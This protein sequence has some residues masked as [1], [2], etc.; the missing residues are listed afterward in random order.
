M[1]TSIVGKERYSSFELLRLLC[2]F[3]IQSMHAYAVFMKDAEGFNFVYGI[4]I[5]SVFNIGVSVFILISGYFG[6]KLSLKKLITLELLVIFY[7]LCSELLIGFVGGEWNPKNLIKAFFPIFTRKYWYMTS[8]MLLLLFSEYINKIPEKLGKKQFEKLLLMLLFVF[9][10]IPTIIQTDIMGDGGKGFANMFLMYLMG[11]YIALYGIACSRKRS[12]I[13]SLVTLLTGFFLN[14]AASCIKGDGVYTPFARDCSLI[15]VIAAVAI[16]LVFQN[17]HFHSRFINRVAGHVVA[18]YLLDI[19]MRTCFYAAV[20]IEAFGN[21]WYLCFILTGYVLTAM[22]VGCIV[23]ELR[24]VTFGKIDKVI[25]DKLDKAIG[26][27]DIFT[28]I[29]AKGERVCEK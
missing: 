12:V 24:R 28:R 19:A 26:K 4:F 5:N 14:L 15:I 21:S 18:I 8:Y 13:V 11:R 23:N 20:D 9:S 16:F 3:G 17:M 29:E 1:Q 6:V 2:I 22:C 25:A 10:I 7:S 27:M